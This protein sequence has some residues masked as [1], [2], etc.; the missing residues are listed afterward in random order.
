[1]KG[2]GSC[3][4]H[5]KQYKGYLDDDDSDQNTDDGASDD[6]YVMPPYE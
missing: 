2:K 3:T 4:G 5:G 1:M 6:D